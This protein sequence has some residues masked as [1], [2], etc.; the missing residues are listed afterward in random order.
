MRRKEHE[1][2]DK[3]IIGKKYPYV[4]E[5]A[6]LIK[7][8]GHRKIWGHDVEHVLL[9]YLI[10]KD[11]KAALSHVLHIL[12]DKYDTNRKRKRVC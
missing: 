3:L 5:F 12:S 9:T 4:H 11:R 1:L 2:L 10:T 8:P 7:G 6:D